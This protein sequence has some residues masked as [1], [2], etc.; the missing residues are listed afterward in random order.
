MMCMNKDPY[1]Q[2][3]LLSAE[4]VAEYLGWVRLRSTAGVRTGACGA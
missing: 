3:D 1:A 2:K 4:D